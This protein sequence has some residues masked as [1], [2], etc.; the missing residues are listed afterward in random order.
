[1]ISTGEDDT[2]SIR[3]KKKKKKKKKEPREEYPSAFSHHQSES[4]MGIIH[5]QQPIKQI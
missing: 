3:T 1:L 2:H 4:E 5:Q